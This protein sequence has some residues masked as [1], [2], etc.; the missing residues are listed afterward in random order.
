MFQTFSKAGCATI[1]AGGEFDS[2]TLRIPSR[3]A[4]LPV[5]APK[6]TFAF[7]T[8]LIAASWQTHSLAISLLVTH[9]PQILLPGVAQGEESYLV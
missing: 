8:T 3:P 7:S 9:Q 1:A 4:D 2:T 5:I 6:N